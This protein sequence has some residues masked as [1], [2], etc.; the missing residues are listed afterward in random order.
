MT[1]E[2]KEFA[3]RVN[4]A[5][6]GCPMNLVYAKVAL[7]KLE[8]GQVLEFILDDGAPVRNVTRSIEEEGHVLLH[9]EQLADGTWAVVVRKSP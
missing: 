3:A 2:G 6:K 8:P 5:G 9:R 4:L 1:D 7:A